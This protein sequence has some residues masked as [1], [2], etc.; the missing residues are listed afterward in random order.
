MADRGGININI[1]HSGLESIIRD[2]K[3]S[4]GSNDLSAALGQVQAQIAKLVTTNS[5]LVGSM[6]SVPTAME[7]IAVS[8]A[9]MTA[10]N[11]MMYE[12]NISEKNRQIRY[13]E[14][15]NRSVGTVDAM[16]SGWGDDLSPA[17]AKILKLRDTVD[18]HID[19]AGNFS[20]TTKE[21][22][23]SLSQLNQGLRELKKTVGS[24]G[25]GGSSNING[26]NVAEAL[27]YATFLSAG[28]YAN[29]GANY[30]IGIQGAS[31]NQLGLMTIQKD[32]AQRNAIAS[33]VSSGGSA[34]G[35][36]IG[37]TLGPLGG[38]IGSAIG[39]SL[40]VAASSISASASAHQSQ[41]YNM[42]TAANMAGLFGAN[43][44]SSLV[45][46]NATYGD[47]AGYFLGQLW[48]HPFVSMM[49]TN[50]YNSPNYGLDYSVNNPVMA[51]Y[52]NKGQGYNAL[53][54]GAL[55]TTG[56]TRYGISVDKSKHLTEALTGFIQKAPG[57]DFTS[58]LSTMNLLTASSFGNDFADKIMPSAFAN[59]GGDLSGF[60]GNVAN[61][62]S[63]TSMTPESATAFESKVYPQG[64]AY[65]SAANNLQTMG[66]FEQLR[67][68]AMLGI[69]HPNLTL[70]QVQDNPSLLKDYVD[71]MNLSINGTTVS[72]A[73]GL[74]A[75]AFGLSNIQAIDNNKI[76]H[77]PSENSGTSSLSTPTAVQSGMNAANN[78]SNQHVMIQ[79][80]NVSIISHGLDKNGN[81]PGEMAN[82]Q[83]QLD[84]ASRGHRLG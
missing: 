10:G 47:K 2:A 16:K 37:G 56:G 84:Q 25:S 53:M 70:K 51:D 28:K 30:D 45:R 67:A 20:S 73:Q 19:A 3:G 49:G 11:K 75:I 60:L 68:A 83:T 58:M 61:L 26:F 74:D 42:Q 81:S 13:S 57:L 54:Y 27:T 71:P 69:T 21:A 8:A 82:L 22:T 63:L 66:P 79:A 50:K 41:N 40:G 18:S 77:T 64:P 29:I 38:V 55:S 39:A 31:A 12:S 35:A 34:I 4:E 43:T 46:P 24:G 5:D 36:V 1:N 76:I 6:K 23:Q 52:L 33:G 59:S 62:S 9:K 44:Q 14:I 15:A 7:S 80:Q 65:T 32:V 17:Q 72:G 78:G 48:N